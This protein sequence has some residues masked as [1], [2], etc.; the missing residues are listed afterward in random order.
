MREPLREPY[1]RH[2]RTMAGR[3]MGLA[4]L[5]AGALAAHPAAAQLDLPSLHA[6][7]SKYLLY[8]CPQLAAA[9]P[10]LLRRKQELEA[11]M[12]K[13]EAGPGGALASTLAYRSDYLAVQP[14]RLSGGAGR[15]AESRG[16][17]AHAELP[18][19]CRIAAGAPPAAPLKPDPPD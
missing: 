13:A 7:P 8:Q 3:L 10:P 2:E 16:A 19:A 9:R 18:P 14:Q 17:G 4:A 6:D 12:A 11:L 5:A 15:P 1:R